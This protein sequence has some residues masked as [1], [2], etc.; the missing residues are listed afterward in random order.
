MKLADRRILYDSR[1][2]GWAHGWTFYQMLA[3]ALAR[4]NDVVYLDAPTSVVRIRGRELPLLRGAQAEAVDGVRVLRSATIPAQRTPWQQQLAARLAAG[5]TARWARRNAFDP[6]LVWCYMPS[7][8]E[9]LE[10]FPRAASVYW[11]GDEVVLPREHELLDRVDAVLCV[12]TPV[13]ERH[14]ATLGERAHFVPVA[15]DFDRYNG[16]VGTGAELL[17]DL[18]R[19]L[20]GYAGFV[21]ERVDEGLLTELGERLTEGT[22]VVAGPAGDEQRRALEGAPRIALLGLQPPEQVP[23]LIDAFDVALVPYRDTVFN[24]SSNPV[25]FYEYLALGKPVVSTDIPTLRPFS[26]VA[27][28]GP[29]ETFVDRV[30]VGAVPGSFDDRVA[31]ARD[32]S[33]GA[34]LARLRALPL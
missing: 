30:L 28:I 13:H 6:D 26:A 16:A 21:N 23:A 10:R 14:R 34:L 29:G 1:N 5:A 17:G 8:V 2:H 20:L 15:C 3:E 32:H 22:V 33:F 24:R 11:T 25:K 7:A 19:P 27:S 4:E 12:S 31:V 9:L 18:E